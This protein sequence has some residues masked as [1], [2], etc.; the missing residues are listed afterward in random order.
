MKKG[1]IVT[2]ALVFVLGIAG[3]AF[4]AANPFT[5]VPAKHWAYDA[6]SKLQKAGIVDGYGDGTFRGDRT[7]TRYEM[8]QIV[9][10]A[11]AK[12]D[13]A[14]AA[15]KAMIDK[16]AVEF[17]SE[18]NNLGVRVTKLEKKVGTVKITGDARLRWNTQPSTPADN[19][20]FKHRMR[21]NMTADV[22]EN[23]SFFG[24]LQYMQEDVGTSAT[25]GSLYVPNML[26]TTK[27]AFNTGATLAA[28][29]MDLKLDTLGYAYGPNGMVDGVKVS[30]GNQVKVAVGYANFRKAFSSADMDDA[31]FATLNYKTSKATE[32]NAGYIKEVGST[33][34]NYDTWTAGVTT[35]FAKNLRFIG[36]YG[37]NTAVTGDPNFYVAKVAYKGA[38]AKKQGTWG[39]E[40]DYYRAET[41]SMVTSA[42]EW[43]TLNSYSIKNNQKAFALTGSYV[44]AKNM[45]LNAWQTFKTKNVSTGADLDN[46]TR[47]QIDFVF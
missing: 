23:T 18:L 16:L 27:N 19:D 14:D 28:G 13:K 40:V 17:A 31:L 39:V 47:A 4:A 37:A 44:L 20:T 11:M 2:L 8:A 34:E 42:G 26:L 38:D 41:G 32:L 5:D 22:N 3:S 35:K 6:V 24:R 9:A 45:T 33:V 10:K 30:A 21:L 12:S 7:M 46:Y 25:A 36:E 43:G 29:R 1:L 15:N